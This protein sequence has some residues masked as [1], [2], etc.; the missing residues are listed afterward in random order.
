MVLYGGSSKTSKTNRIVNTSSSN[1]NKQVN[2]NKIPISKMTMLDRLQSKSP[3]I[4]NKN[5]LQSK[6][7][8]IQNKNNH[9][10]FL[11]TPAAHAEIP[12]DYLPGDPNRE[13]SL[14]D[15]ETKSG[16]QGLQGEFG[17]DKK[18][19]GNK[20]NV[21]SRFIKGISNQATDYQ[22]I[23]N[24][25]YEH[26]SIL[27][28]AIDKSLQG[29]FGAAGKLIQ[30]NPVRF[31]GNI[32]VEVATFLVPVGPALKVVKGVSIAVKQ[33]QKL[34]KI[35]EKIISKITKKPERI[36]L[37]QVV[38]VDKQGKPYHSPWFNAN[39]PDPVFLY[40]SGIQTEGGVAV[41]EL[42]MTRDQSTHY[43]ANTIKMTERDEPVGAFFTAKQLEN[44]K[45]II[46]DTLKVGRTHIN[47][48]HVRKNKMSMYF[49]RYRSDDYIY[50]TLKDRNKAKTVLTINKDSDYQGIANIMTRT[51]HTKK[52]LKIWLNKKQQDPT[53]TLQTS[54]EENSRIKFNPI[55]SKMDKKHDYKKFIPFATTVPILSATQKTSS[56]RKR[57]KSVGNIKNN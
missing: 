52:G 11:N 3:S 41:R 53:K 31:A 20:D 51:G 45:T 10:S 46:G 32:A 9:Q 43:A 17:A 5:N 7:P 28:Q 4:Q 14:A 19:I 13:I 21:Q 56:L 50:T 6:S 39:K 34:P 54:Y 57:K 33:S 18:S 42:K 25:E 16:L 40:K 1:I 12:A 55:L 24:P 48:P 8:S 26:K 36:S 49:N 44:P 22:S 2:S 38:G 37:W 23:I 47:I 30:D 15:R 35:Q 27:N 29:E